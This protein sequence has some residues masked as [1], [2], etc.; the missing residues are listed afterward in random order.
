MADVKVL[1]KNASGEVREV[2]GLTVDEVRA[3]PRT[4]Y[5]S[6]YC[7]HVML[8]GSEVK[9]AY[10]FYTEAEK[11]VYNKYR[12]EH[13]GSGS[14]SGSSSSSKIPSVVREKLLEVLDHLDEGPAKTELN[15]IVREYFPDPRIE[16]AKLAVAG[17]DKD[18]LALVLAQM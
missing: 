17:I 14:G 12:K 18:V 5:S 3:M 1:K 10:C 7:P 4:R 15:E 13:L 11:S 8:A 6:T 16:A 2:A 9:L